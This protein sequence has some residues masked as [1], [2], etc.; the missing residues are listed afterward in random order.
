MASL[1]TDA[2]KAGAMR[3][4]RGEVL[5]A[6]HHSS[7]SDPPDSEPDDP[8][9]AEWFAA[10]R[11]ELDARLANP[12][13][14]LAHAVG[15]RLPA[16]WRR[17]ALPRALVLTS[18]AQWWLPRCF[19]G[20]ALFY[21]AVDNYAVGYGWSPDQVRRW[22]QRFIHRCHRVVVVSAALAAELIRRHDLA[23]TRLVISPN[24]IPAVLIPSQP[25][26]PRRHSATNPPL[27]GVIGRISSRLRLDW[28][29]QAVEALPWLHWRFVGD[30]DE[31]EMAAGDGDHLAWLQ[32]HPRCQFIGRVPYRDLARH[33]ADV[34]VGV[35]PY[36][37]RSINPW[38]SPMRLFVHLASGRPLLGTAG[39]AQLREFEPSITLC[40]DADALIS[41]L[42]ALRERGFDDGRLA[43]RLDVARAHTWEHRARAMAALIEAATPGRSA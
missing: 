36:S 20:A 10:L 41:R 17:E 13:E 39:C 35:L 5:V 1:A 40:D 23:P 4:A 15:A 42:V 33:A 26:P 21:Y 24:A 16:R 28:L 19:A 2:V 32:R 9:I 25:P 30:V 18:P 34:D 31:P 27:A 11:L 29:R 22:E 37:E 7:P 38:G 12:R 14:V 43:A 8:A 3:R 6:S